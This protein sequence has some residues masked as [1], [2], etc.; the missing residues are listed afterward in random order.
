MI[1]TGHSDGRR[2]D[3]PIGWSLFFQRIGHRPVQGQRPTHAPR[4]HRHIV[5]QLLAA[6]RQR[7]IQLW[8]LRGRQ[9]ARGSGADPA[10]AAYLARVT[11]DFLVV[12]IPSA[13]MMCER[14]LDDA[15][16]P[17]QLGVH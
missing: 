1:L 10:A 4:R 16:G 14:V 9:P 2:V 5:A 17:I 3:C 11:P 6:D 12:S 15:P 8:P 13:R 7:L